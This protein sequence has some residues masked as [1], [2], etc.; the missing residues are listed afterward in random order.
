MET[1]KNYANFLIYI[2]SGKSLIKLENY[3][4]IFRTKDNTTNRSDMIQEQV[5]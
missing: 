1:M 5:V 3:K 2:I 4:K